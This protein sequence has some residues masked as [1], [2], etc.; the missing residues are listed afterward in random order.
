MYSFAQRTDTC[1]LDEPFYASYLKK[2]GAQ[3]P[4]RD[5]VLDALPH[6]EE[7][8]FS[9]I[10]AA[11][12]KP[13]LFIKGMA[14]HLVGIDHQ[15]LASMTCLFLIRD[16]RQL[17]ASFAQVIE[18]PTMGDIGLEDSLALFNDLRLL[19]AHCTVLDSGD[20]LNDPPEILLRTCEAIGIPFDPN[21]LKWPA[22]ARPEDGVWAPYW[23]AAVHASTGFTQ[24]TSNSRPLPAHCEDLYRAALP[25]YQRL[26]E[27][28]STS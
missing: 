12:D 23:Y 17:I 28:A 10:N 13:V 26:K 2:S 20:L 5:E 4:G 19:G 7:G 1:V 15:R 27:Y 22:G 9:L 16:P 6:D 24:Q 18:R 25:L 14:H 11:H 8:V 3:R 21:M